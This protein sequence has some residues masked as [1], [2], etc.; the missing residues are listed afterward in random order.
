MTSI[1]QWV[2]RQ[3]DST[4]NKSIDHSTSFAVPIAFKQDGPLPG[5]GLEMLP[6]E[7]PDGLLGDVVTQKLGD[8]ESDLRVSVLRVFRFA[9]HYKLYEF[10]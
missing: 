9:P 2:R 4:Q 3:I 10:W 6:E 7:A 8:K 5:V 1:I